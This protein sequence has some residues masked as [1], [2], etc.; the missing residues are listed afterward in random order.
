V[1]YL[2]DHTGM[3]PETLLSAPLDPIAIESQLASF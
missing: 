2:L 3:T 1:A